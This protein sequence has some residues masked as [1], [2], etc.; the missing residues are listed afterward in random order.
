MHRCGWT[1]GLPDKFWC[2]FPP[3]RIL[4]MPVKQLY[5]I[6][7]VVHFWPYVNQ[8]S[9]R[10]SEFLYKVS[11]KSALMKFNII[12]V[13]VY[14]L[15][16]KVHLRPHINEDLL[17][18]NTAE[19][20]DCLTNFCGSLPY[21]INTLYVPHYNQKAN[22]LLVYFTLQQRSMGQYLLKVFQ[23]L[24]LYTGIVSFVSARNWWHQLPVAHAGVEVRSCM[25]ATRRLTVQT[26][27][28]SLFSQWCVLQG[29]V[30]VLWS[31]GE[32]TRSPGL[33]HRKL[34]NGAAY[35]LQT[36]AFTDWWK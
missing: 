24:G 33:V 30:F 34:W 10:I 21:R 18:I 9:L 27:P 6:Y 28:Y 4:P 36:R 32:S 17:W 1:T 16:R 7:G 8:A 13:T 11:W 22:F 25:N 31:S 19:K 29:T 15:Y 3:N 23:K 2:T 26:E 12:C 35:E 14:W 5:G 20:R